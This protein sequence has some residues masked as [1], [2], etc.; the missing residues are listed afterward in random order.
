MNGVTRELDVPADESAAEML[1]DRL[2]LTGAKLV[3]GEGVCGACTVLMDGVPMT[4]CLLPASALDGRAVTTVEGLGLQLHPVQR[5]FIAHDALQCGYCTPGFVVEAVAFHDRWRAERGSTEPTREEIVEALSGHLCRCGAYVGIIAAVRAACAGR[6]DAGAAS[7]PRLEA[8]DKVSGRAKYTTD[9]RLPGQLEGMILRSPQ[10]HAT[11][12]AIDLSAARRLPGVRAVVE[13]LHGERVVRY[14]GQE[15]AAVAATDRETAKRALASISV[16]Y[17][18]LSAVVG[19]DKARAPQAARVYRGLCLWRRPPNASEGLLIPA[20]WR[21][22]VRG[23]V[24]LLS[25]RRRTARRLVAQ[26]RESGDRM[27]IEG[28]W[29]TDAQIHTSLEPHAC[30]ACWDGDVLVVH[31]STQAAAYVARCIAKRFQLD[32]DKVRVIA[33]HVGGGFGAKLQLTPETVAAI[34]LARKAGAPVRLV[35]ERSEEMTVGGYRPGAEIHV[36]LL[37][38]SAKKLQA[39]QMRAYAD[40]GIAAGS[41]IALFARMIYPASAKTL[42]DYNV[43]SNLP[44]GAPFRGPSGPVTAWAL[45]QAIDEA[46]NRL[47]EDAIALRRRWDPNPLRQRLYDWAADL[48]LWRK[49]QP[50]NSKSGRYR[51]GV[52]VAAANWVYFFQKDCEV[53]VG[54]EDGRVYAATAVQDIGTGIRSVLAEAVARTLSI[55]RSLVEVRVGDT[56]WVKGPSSSA[57]RTTATVVP[58][59][60]DAARRLSE[61]LKS[62]ARERGLAQAPWSEILSAAPHLMV[63]ARRPPDDRSASDAARPL[64]GTGLVGALNVWIFK[65]LKLGIGRGYTGA[66]HVAEVEVDTRLGKTRVLNVAAGLAAGRIASP[67]LARSQCYGGVI[68]GI[69][70]ALYEH[71]AVDERSGIVLS[72]G[73]EDYR[74]PGIGDVPQ[75]DLH[76]DERG[77]EHVLGGGVGLS[78]LSTLGVAASIGNAVYNAT[79]WRPY[80]L[81]I[82]PDRLLRGVGS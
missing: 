55:E 70:Y 5:A 6:F 41:Q 26:A 74:I 51:R 40:A 31:V 82:R 14:V 73:L 4:S 53:E 37:A 28:R 45:E 24:S 68:Q 77:F 81:P 33:E 1:R 48:E 67:H 46:A 21:G 25:E 80:E 75:I 39:V 61:K 16:D 42:L 59:A 58:A 36:A 27:L 62:F 47:G 72:A 49:R 69:G 15:V 60:I 22:N 44:P 65:W 66:V 38:N 56:R 29:R 34:E 30:V 8:C 13:L 57:S 71:R 79:G 7:G 64:A 11:V 78:E 52:G 76:F 43:V 9:V 3:C 10:A 12:R 63:R 23:P 54:I 32:D 19:M 50:P 18:P 20:F 35:L 2:G 17:Q